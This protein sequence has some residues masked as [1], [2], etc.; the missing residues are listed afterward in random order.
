FGFGGS[1]YHVTLEEYRGTAPVPERLRTFGTDAERLRQA[2][3]KTSTPYGKVAFLFPG[4]GSQ[5]VGMGADVAMAFDPARAA[6]DAAPDVADVVFP[7]P[8]FGADRERVERERLTATENAQPA[9]GTASRALLA[10]L[11][12]LGVRPDMV[13]GHSFGEVTALHAAG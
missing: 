3:P 8:G 5:Y 6:W 4:Q 9:I 1:N 10:L 2:V 11:D 7:R 12:E 13:G